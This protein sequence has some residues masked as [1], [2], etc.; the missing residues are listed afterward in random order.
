MTVEELEIRYVVTQKTIGVV[1]THKII[2]RLL[3]TPNSG[4]FVVG[5][6]DN[7]PEANAIK[8]CLCL[9]NND[10]NLGS[11]DKVKNMKREFRLLFKIL[12]GCV[13]PREGSTGQISWD[14]KHFIFYLKS[15]DGINLS[16][17]IFNHLCEAIKDNTNLLKMNVPY[18]RLLS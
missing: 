17:Y 3:C 6:K 2:F 14:H 1:I 11:S 9:F 8:W 16:S 15:E 12:I 13:I 7:S 4:R 10:D 5:T 18:A